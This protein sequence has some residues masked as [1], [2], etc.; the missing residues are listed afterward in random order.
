[1]V[2]TE[3]HHTHYF[4]GTNYTIDKEDIY[5]KGIRTVGGIINQL[6]KI[7]ENL[8]SDKSE[9]VLEFDANISYVLKEGI[10]QPGTSEKKNL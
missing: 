4:I 9:E 3:D 7:I 10:M 2:K 1:M 5:V 6:E 8:G